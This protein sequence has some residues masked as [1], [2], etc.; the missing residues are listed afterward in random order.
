MI[1]NACAG[2]VLGNG[3]FA[4]EVAKVAVRI[5]DGGHDR[6]G[7]NI[8]HPI[9][10]GWR[11]LVIGGDVA[12]AAVADHDDGIVVDRLSVTD[13]DAPTVKYSAGTCWKALDQTSSRRY[14]RQT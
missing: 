8:N 3:R 13:D 10:L 1:E 6:F 9:T 2:Q 12:D 14:R 11:E 5:D 7:R 4:T